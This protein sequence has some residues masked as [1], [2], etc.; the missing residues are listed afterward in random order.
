[1]AISGPVGAFLRRAER[2][3]GSTAEGRLQDR[4]EL[5]AQIRSIARERLRG[6]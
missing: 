4:P 6:G 3:Y 1:V 2:R 5:R